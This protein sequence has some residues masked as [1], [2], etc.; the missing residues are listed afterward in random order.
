MLFTSLLVFVL[1]ET[2][3][4]PFIVSIALILKIFIKKY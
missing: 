2:R 1:L 4:I 3:I